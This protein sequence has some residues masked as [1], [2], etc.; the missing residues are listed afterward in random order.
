MASDQQSHHYSILKID[1]DENSNIYISVNLSE[2]K[3]ACWGSQQRH[4]RAFFRLTQIVCPSWFSEVAENHLRSWQ[5]HPWLKRAANHS[6]WYDIADYKT[7]D[8][9]FFQDGIYRI[10]HRIIALR[11]LSLKKTR[12]YN[13]SSTLNNVLTININIF[14]RLSISDCDYLSIKIDQNEIIPK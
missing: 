5:F 1:L 7:S 2:Q 3:C 13:V 4:S 9:P 6:V 11:N 14:G 10:F 8:Y 12:T